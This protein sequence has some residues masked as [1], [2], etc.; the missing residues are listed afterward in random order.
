MITE[1]NLE[2]ASVPSSEI[3]ESSHQGMTLRPLA[4]DE[5]VRRTTEERNE[6]IKGQSHAGQYLLSFCRNVM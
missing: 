6:E 5:D 4:C 2:I 3:A 1:W